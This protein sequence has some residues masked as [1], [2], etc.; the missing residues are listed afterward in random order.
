M[1]PK[2]SSSSKFLGQK[3]A[4][5]SHLKQYKIMVEPLECFHF[6]E[7]IQQ[8]A[9]FVFTNINYIHIFLHRLLTFIGHFNA[10][11]RILLSKNDSYTAI[12]IIVAQFE[13]A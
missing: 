7:N 3:C 2:C 11:M 9:I 5:K 8:R 10:E 12:L 13:L 4:A 1:D 6:Y